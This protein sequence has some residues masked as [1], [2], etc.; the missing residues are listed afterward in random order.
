MALTKP[1]LAASFKNMTIEDLDFPVYATP[2]L[3]GIRALKI[4]GELVSRTFKPIRNSVINQAIGELI[5]D[6]SD[7]E[8]LSGKTFQD[9]TS[10]IMSMD[11]GIG[12]DTT[13]FWFDYVKDGI[14]KPYLERIRDIEEHV[15]MNPDILNDLR[16]KIVP[17]IPRKINTVE[18]LVEFEKLCLEQNF[19]GVMIRSGN[20]V[21]KCGRSTEKQGILIKL[22][23][24]EDD[25]A[26]ITGYTSMQTNTNEKTMN[27]L[28][29]MKRSSHQAG[30][31]DLDMIGALEV[32]WNGIH[33]SIGTG[34][35][36]ALRKQLWE[37]RDELVGRIVKFK[38]F[39][40]GIKTAPRFPV[41][42]GWR[43]KD[44]M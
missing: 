34:F 11:G 43:D 5:P 31:H 25:E 36:H 22:K 14:D 23:K 39:A 37:D 19:E 7:G 10:T 28:G 29:D 20:G 21:Y 44:D 24:F 2:K 9:A 4:N 15:K 6:G 17:L 30:K 38:Y 26:V 12:V 35:D 16:V 1:L 41:F 13:F 40:Q 32:D 33:F 27:E 8:I 18:E 3:D 42:I